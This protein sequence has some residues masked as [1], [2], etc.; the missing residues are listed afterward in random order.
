MKSAE[1]W[2]EEFYAENASEENDKGTEKIIED[3]RA[4][5]REE[6]WKA[7]EV[8]RTTICKAL[9]NAGKEKTDG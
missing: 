4:E 2:R 6:C 5:Q 3:I 9:L 1:E 7:F 8:M